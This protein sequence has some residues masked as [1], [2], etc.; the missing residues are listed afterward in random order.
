MGSGLWRADG[1]APGGDTF[2]EVSLPGFLFYFPSWV[3]CTRSV[4]MKLVL[5]AKT[6]VMTIENLILDQNGFVMN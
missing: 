4:C 2:Y 5:E 3:F 1:K 6:K